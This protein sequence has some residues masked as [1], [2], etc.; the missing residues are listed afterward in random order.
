MK[1][2]NKF[3]NYYFGLISIALFII[4]L[5]Y[6]FFSDTWGSLHYVIFTPIG[7]LLFMFYFLLINAFNP[8]KILFKVAMSIIG[9]LLVFEV[10]LFILD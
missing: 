9:I 4:W 5:G 1:T 6:H 7:C 8:N 10:I 2:R 3:I